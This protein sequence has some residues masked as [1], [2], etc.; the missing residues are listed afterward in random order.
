MAGRPAPAPADTLSST[1]R[2]SG[3]Q[4]FVLNPNGEALDGTPYTLNLGSASAEVYVIATAGNYHMKPRVERLD[5]GAAADG[6]RAAAQ[7]GHHPHPRPEAAGEQVSPRLKWITEFN[8]FNDGPPVWDGSADPSRNRSVASRPAVAE[9]DEFEFLDVIDF[10]YVPATARKVVTDGTTS[11][12]VWVSDWEWCD[13]TPCYGSRVT[14][15][16]VDAAAERFLRPGSGNDIHDWITAIF[17]KPWGPHDNDRLIPPRRPATRFTSCC[18]TSRMTV[19]PPDRA[20]SATSAGCTRSCDSR[21]RPYTSF[22]P[23]GWRSS[24][25]RRTWRRRPARPG[26]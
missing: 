23:N 26:R 1:Y 4:V 18:S 2:G 10:R 16:M 22:R 8:N 20:S 7:A 5:L 25:T 17:G 21:L 6:G 24:W 14:Q 11:V 19:P 9:G 13:E 12:A 3:D 15:E